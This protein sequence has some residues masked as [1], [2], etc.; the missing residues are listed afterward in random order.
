M[1]IEI[2]E[3]NCKVKA[4]IGLVRRNVYRETFVVYKCEIHICWETKQRGGHS[5][6]QVPQCSREKP[7]KLPSTE[8]SDSET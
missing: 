3:G 7:S 2:S 5:P 4:G 1:F 6:S 8:F